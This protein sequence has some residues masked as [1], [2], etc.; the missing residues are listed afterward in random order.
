MRF[1]QP[2][3][4]WSFPATKRVRAPPTLLPRQRGFDALRAA[5]QFRNHAGEAGIAGFQR[6][7]V[8]H[9]N[10]AFPAVGFATSFTSGEHHRPSASLARVATAL[11]S[12][13][14]AV[15]STLLRTA[16]A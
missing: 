5:E 11:A 3:A 14:A 6:P 10:S 16:G 15:A 9:E 1:S 13:R 7:F 2:Q 4:A 8:E 12:F